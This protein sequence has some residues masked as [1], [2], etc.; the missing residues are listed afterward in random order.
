MTADA[1]ADRGPIAAPIAMSE[2]R[3]EHDPRS[4]PKE[5]VADRPDLVPLLTSFLTWTLPSA[6]FSTTAVSDR[7]QAVRVLN[8][9][10]VLV[11][12]PGR[13]PAW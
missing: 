9:V 5:P 10:D 7:V 3:E 2:D 13:H 8:V 12:R 6:S 1:V 4:S 11:A